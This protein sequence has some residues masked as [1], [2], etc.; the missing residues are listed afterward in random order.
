MALAA[1][2]AHCA[3]P[4]RLGGMNLTGT[5]SVDLG[6]GDT[7]DEVW[8]P[9]APTALRLEE[10]RTLLPGGSGIVL[11]AW[12][13]NDRT[14]SIVV[15]R[16]RF[17]LGPVAIGGKI[18]HNEY[19]YPPQ[20]F[21]QMR[22]PVSEATQGFM[23]SQY[24]YGAI[25]P[26]D[27]LSLPM[28][29]IW[30]GPTGTALGLGCR[31]DEA[32]VRVGVIGGEAGRLETNIAIYRTLA[33]GGRLYLGRVLVG[34]ARSQ[35]DSYEAMAAL[36]LLCI[37]AGVVQAPQKPPAFLK[38]LQIA[39]IGP[40]CPPYNTFDDIRAKLPA[41]AEGGINALIVGGRL[42]YCRNSLRPELGDFLPILRGGKYT[43]DDT[44]SGGEAGLRRLIDEGHRLGMKVFCWGPTLAGIALES[45]EVQSKPDWWI[46]KADGSLNLWYQELAPPDASVEGWRQWVL[47]T[48]R[49]IA[50]EQRF[51]GCWLDS[52]WKDHALNLN[53]ASG[54]YGGPNGAKVS[55]LR[56]IRQLAK[57]LNPSFLLM[58]ESGGAETGSAVDLCYVRAL[59]V[60]P[61]VPPERMQEV[62]RTEEACRLD[63]E[64]PFGQYQVDPG[65]LGDEHP[66]RKRLLVRDSWKATLFLVNTL[67]RVPAY[68]VGDPIAKL[69]DD[70]ELGEVA[71]RLMAVRRSR[72]ELVDGKVVFD[73]IVSSAPQVVHF[74]RVLGRKASLVLVNCGAESA[75]TSITL[76][77]ETAR[78]VGHGWKPKDLLGQAVVTR[79]A[80]SVAI[81]VTLPAYRGAIMPME[82]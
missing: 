12:L 41:M 26:T 7:P 63:G 40:Y 53:S 28:A 11:Q 5:W 21:Q 3:E 52:T 78:L 46:R 66:V 23:N 44:V 76:S 51:D 8:T 29:A 75:T 18:D 80:G 60:F 43:V 2:Q 58:A 1:P 74:C 32:V 73:G 47:G 50:E 61:L 48:V 68:F 39:W 17:T 65:P 34:I 30:D 31:N 19:L 64:R 71:R 33:P 22:G 35:G 25:Q 15:G 42:W 6:F 82:D 36:K 45:P 16:A 56:E 62:V 55:L 54:W 27:K 57:S 9:A 20:V 49:Q 37:A 14:E 4:L 38:G 81:D 13:S 77:G 79:V 10:S 69:V 24:I 59:G 72:S 70:P 67:P